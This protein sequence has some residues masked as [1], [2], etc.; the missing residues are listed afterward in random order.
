MNSSTTTSSATNTGLLLPKLSQQ[1]DT[2][3]MIKIMH[4]GKKVTLQR[5]TAMWTV[6][7]KAN[8]PA[9][10]EKV[11]E[12]LLGL[13]Y[14]QRL[15][16]KTKNPQN[17]SILGLTDPDKSTSKAGQIQLLD[18][19]NKLVTQ[20]TLGKRA[21]SE[22]TS[23]DNLYALVEDDPQTWLVLG[24]LPDMGG[25]GAW[26]E[27]NLL[28]LERNRITAVTITHTDGEIIK[29]T[30]KVVGQPKLTLDGIKEGETLKSEYMLA[31]IFERFTNLQLENVRLAKDLAWP[32]TNPLQVE[33]QTKEGLLIQIVVA[34]IDNTPWLRFTAQATTVATTSSDSATT[35]P[36]TNTVAPEQQGTATSQTEATNQQSQT[37]PQEEATELNARWNGW[38]YT[39]ADWA[40][41]TLNK[42]RTDLV[43]VSAATN[44]QEDDTTGSV[45]ETQEDT[46]TA[47]STTTEL[48]TNPNEQQTTATPTET[49]PTDDETGTTTVTP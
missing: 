31:D 2:V 44:V 45:A 13:A 27:R 14:M 1:L 40:Y 19:Q 35:P 17:Y 8:Y 39:L 34:T 4:A 30:P 32:E 25:P 48:H 43:T 20:V 24:R 46:T 41:Q 33:V 21:D 5:Q 49:M 11:R 7:E 16:P 15:E 22:H 26:L 42:R 9:T 6:A 10:I 38:A 3:H 28:I 18:K 12:L 23:S 37:S 29:V 36:Q 47:D